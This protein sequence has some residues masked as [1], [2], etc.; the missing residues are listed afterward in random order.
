MGD[1]LR[2]EVSQISSS[3]VDQLVAETLDDANQQALIEDFIQKVGA[4]S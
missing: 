4:G 3:V 2:V 1:E